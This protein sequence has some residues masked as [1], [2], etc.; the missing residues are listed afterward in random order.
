M[1]HE[2]SLVFAAGHPAFAGHFPGAPIVPGVL[3]L[4]AA[5]HAAEQAGM[6]ATGIPSAKFLQP[7]G[8]GQP[9][10]LACAGQGDRVRFAITRD[11]VDVA[12]GQLLTG[13]PA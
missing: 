3:L 11:G 8:P 12:T 13:L 7:V 2:T 4:D 5:L 10:E 9:L 1:N 6:A